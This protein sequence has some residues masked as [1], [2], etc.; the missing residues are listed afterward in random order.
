MDAEAPVT[1]GMLRSVLVAARDEVVNIHTPGPAWGT[2]DRLLTH[3]NIATAD[4]QHTPAVTH[5]GKPLWQHTCGYVLAGVTD[6]GMCGGC[7]KPRAGLSRRL[8]VRTGP[9]E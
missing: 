5:S 7:G 2:L 6:S 4:T 3:L 1:V 8:Y 9:P